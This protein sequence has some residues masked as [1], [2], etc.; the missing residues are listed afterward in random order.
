M[1]NELRI[2]HEIEKINFAT[3]TVVARRITQTEGGEFVDYEGRKVN[4]LLSR[5]S[6]MKYGHMPSV[7]FFAHEVAREATHSEAFL[8]FLDKAAKE[9][10]TV[11]ITS[12]G[13]YNVPSASNLLLK[14]SA[15]LINAMC[16]KLGIPPVK[17][18]EQT[19]LGESTLNYA[20]RGLEGRTVDPATRSVTPKMFKDQA[21]IFVDDVYISGT[22]A[23]RTKKRLIL[24]GG[25][26]STF[27]LF[28]MQVDPEIVRKTDG[29]VEDALN[30]FTVDG[31]LNGLDK[32]L[33][34]EFVATQK[35]IRDIL[36]FENRSELPDYLAT[37]DP[38]TVAILYTAATQNGF[39]ERWKGIFCESVDILEA[40]L[41]S[42]GYLND[43]GEPVSEPSRKVA[44][45]EVELP[46]EK[47]IGKVSAWHIDSVDDLPHEV[48]VLYSRM[49]YS[50]PEASSK[51]AS[52]FANKIW[53]NLEIWEKLTSG[54]EVMISSSA[55]GA[56]PTAAGLLIEDIALEL[57]LKGAKVGTF[58]I[59][60]EGDFGVTD[61]GTMSPEKRATCLAKFKTFI[62]PENLERIS[63]KFVLIVDD[64]SATGSHEKKIGEL[65][66]N[67]D[68]E[69]FAF[70][71]LVDFSQQLAFEAPDT[72]EKLNHF[73]SIRLLDLAKR[74]T[75]AEKNGYEVTLN[76]RTVRYIVENANKNIGEYQEFL[77]LIS[78]EV[79][80]DLYNSAVSRDGYAVIPKFV[81][82]IQILENT[83]LAKGLVDLESINKRR[84]RTTVFEVTFENDHLVDM[85]TG[86]NL[87]YV[88]E[89]YSL[90]KFGSVKEINFFADIIA[91][92]FVDRLDDPEDNLL[93][94][95]KKIQ[96]SGEFLLHMVAGS[97]NVESAAEFVYEKAVVMMNT[98]LALRGLPTMISVTPTRLQAITGEYASMQAADRQNLPKA[99]DHILPGTELYQM[100]A[101]LIYG[102][103]VRITGTTADGV[104][105]SAIA[106]GVNSYS[107]MYAVVVD[108][109]IAAIMPETESRLNKMAV[110]GGLDNSIKYILNQPEFRPVQRLLRVLFDEKNFSDFDKFMSE[111]I[112]SGSLVK[113]YIAA[114][115]NDFLKD[116][117][118]RPSI[119]ALRDV[120][121][122][123]GL[124][125]ENGRLVQS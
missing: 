67:T 34:E 43:L 56:V 22:V 28:G 97:R 89:A 65:L 14:E 33:R 40:H 73:A 12:P 74:Y 83:L 111:E 23:E 106:H 39:R 3:E 82:G 13:V 62:S 2:E 76:T 31:T 117:K 52:I 100:G 8:N 29:K 113:L 53:N 48:G 93:E 79:A 92:Q 125:T 104:E 96:E 77:D 90:M 98:E 11:F 119:L 122:K 112:E 36:S 54:Q 58:K 25:V 101:H 61:Y 70:C 38:D 32:V 7:R 95:I 6:L 18:A 57:S 80:L 15:V 72:E 37:L 108:P 71:V 1:I 120:L 35:T 69:S 118:Y 102:D 116:Q 66:D 64:L 63:G 10:K 110:K 41:K 88:G 47:G 124:V 24:E 16:S 5:F 51:L 107:D 4:G 85:N 68:I 26:D 109:K 44:K 121:I 84:N 103:D 46:S 42:K 19:R 20:E 45:S 86:E 75:E 91:A 59:D 94:S 115:A 114:L 17:V 87:D 30:K 55:F 99:T 105:R 60:W 78:P 27:F 81:K 50:D 123:K 9:G 49:K 21:V